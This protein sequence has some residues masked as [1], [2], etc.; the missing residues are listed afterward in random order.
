MD[1]NVNCP[2]LHVEGLG[3]NWISVILETTLNF[4]AELL[5]PPFLITLQFVGRSETGKQRLQNFNT[6]STCYKIWRP[7]GGS[8]VTLLLY[9][10]NSLLTAASARQE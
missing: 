2:N 1:F 7:S 10:Y 9:K 8:A 4:F 6:S 3:A 5:R